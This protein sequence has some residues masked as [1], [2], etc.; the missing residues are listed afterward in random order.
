M[1]LITYLREYD[2]TIVETYVVDVPQDLLVAADEDGVG[3][4]PN[5]DALDQWVCDNSDADKEE[6]LGMIEDSLAATWTR[7][8]A[9][10]GEGLDV[11][12]L[13]E[14]YMQMNR[15]RREDFLHRDEEP[16]VYVRRHCPECGLVTTVPL[17]YSVY[18]EWMDRTPI[19]E[20]IDDEDTI[21]VVTTGRCEMHRATKG[22]Q[23]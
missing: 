20:L 18:V 17:R 16:E 3:G 13:E 7:H 14:N 19:E 12:Q 22:E 15:D 4:G 10:R 21:E 8:P 9:E 6:S 5:A 11:E 1:P 2:V 23:G